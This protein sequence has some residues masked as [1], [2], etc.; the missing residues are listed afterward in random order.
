MP[1]CAKKT[2]AVLK[3]VGVNERDALWWGPCLYI[4]Q[5]PTFTTEY[6]VV[7]PTQGRTLF[8]GYQCTWGV[9]RYGEPEILKS[10]MVNQEGL[11]PCYVRM[12]EA[13]TRRWK[14]GVVSNLTLESLAPAAGV[15]SGSQ[16][17]QLFKQLPKILVEAD[18]RRRLQ[19][20]SRSRYRVGSN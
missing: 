19:Q 12:F 17:R 6:W 7:C 14:A 4:G 11:P 15:A 2:L 1:R 20:R 3:W 16:V 13:M 10:L 18:E 8:S 9:N 5:T